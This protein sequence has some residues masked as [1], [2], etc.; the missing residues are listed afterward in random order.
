MTNGKKDIVEKIYDIPLE[1]YLEYVD[2]IPDVTDEEVLNY[3]NQIIEGRKAEKKLADPVDEN[4]DH[5]YH[6][7]LEEKV[8]AGNEAKQNLIESKFGVVADMAKKFVGQGAS[9]PDLIREGNQ[10]VAKAVENLMEHNP[11]TF[12]KMVPSWVRERMERFVSTKSE[13]STEEDTEE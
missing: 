1:E 3:Y 4:I 10:G 11:D 5:D 7:E 9:M 13:K 2:R 6:K 12:N 8:T